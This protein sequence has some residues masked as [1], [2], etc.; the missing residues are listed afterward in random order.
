MLSIIV[1]GTSF[2]LTFT[3]KVTSTP[4]RGRTGHHE[5]MASDSL[6]GTSSPL[7]HDREVAL[8]HGLKLLGDTWQGL[9]SAR[10][11]QPPVSVI[12]R[13]LLE[14]PLPAIGVGVSQ[15]LD[16]AN[17][18]LNESIA[19]SRPRYFGYVGSSGL[20]SAVLA[21]AL[22]SSHDV[23]LAAESEA[24]LLAERQTLRWM[25]EFIGFPVADGAF[26]SGGML[27]NLTALMAART[28]ALPDARISGLEGMRPT[29]YASAEAHASVERA[30]EVLG[31]GRCNVRAVPIDADRRM[32]VDALRDLIESDV[33]DG[34]QPI[35]VV[36][37]A[38][39]T[40]T[41]AVD[42]IGRV[43]GVC[44]DFGVWLHVDGA[45]GLP[46]AST[47][48]ARHL[49]V[50]LELADSVSLD[51]HKWMFIPKACGVLL[52]RHPG[53]LLAAFRHDSSYMIEED[54]YSHPVE[55]TL[56]YSRPFRSLKL[57]TALRSHGADAFRDAITYNLEL[58]AVL[59]D[60]VR[61]H[62]R[63]EL[64]V[65]QPQLSTVPFRYVPVDTS[66]DV[67]ALNMKLARR[68]QADGRVYVTSATVDGHACLRPCIVNFRT[69]ESDID[70]LVDTAVEWGTR[71]ESGG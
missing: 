22:A 14:E 45:Y 41:G 35:A 31:I 47:Q 70:V 5:V 37:T 28:R 55:T 16:E 25:G 6:G 21:D 62:P 40:L 36:A 24:A 1:G 9:D 63:L 33:S 19:Q 50:G 42:P 61:A 56:E 7:S 26:T 32:R 58:A 67:N 48:R 29:V 8:E 15:A 65:P 69:T 68:M 11:D 23:N 4:R 20:E 43:A 57:W 2:I 53:S 60:R 64:L 34:R 13:E 17:H 54:G 39:T 10:P 27:S 12:T 66:I 49:F 18:V 51:A 3:T 71:L 59:A 38:G 46:A 30:A 52:V 44:S